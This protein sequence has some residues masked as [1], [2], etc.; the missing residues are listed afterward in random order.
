MALT[1]VTHVSGFSATN[2]V[3]PL[4]ASGALNVA[5]GDAL[6]GF[7]GWYGG[8]ATPTLHGASNSFQF[9]FGSDGNADGYLAMGY[10]IVSTANA[11]ETFHL[12]LSAART[13]RAF[14]IWHFHPDDDETVSL[15]GSDAPKTGS[16]T[17]LT[18]ENINTT[19]T[20]EIVVG[21]QY[22]DNM[23][24]TTVAQIGD[25]NA[26]D[27][28]DTGGGGTWY[29]ILNAT[30]ANIHSQC[31]S[32]GSW[33]CNIIALKSEA[34]G[35]AA[36]TESIGGTGPALAGVNKRITVQARKPTGAI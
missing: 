29:R 27:T 31:T 35:G 24:G 21:A 19:G 1:I 16:I 33:V 3:G 25:V 13:F 30:A 4:N 23:D 17:S 36:Y 7:A 6:V 34:A 10:C 28:H 32:S 26:T 14:T 9:P 18:S 12:D 20:D 8:D 22:N 11:A 15:D 2:S 5:V